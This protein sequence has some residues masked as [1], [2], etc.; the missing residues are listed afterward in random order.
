MV[1]M[2][3]EIM[4]SLGINFFIFTSLFLSDYMIFLFHILGK[5]SMKITKV[6]KI[7]KQLN[8]GLTSL[9]LVLRN[10]PQ[11]RNS[12]TTNRH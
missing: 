1:V 6:L 11:V 8:K 4:F 3:L 12:T 5:G 7:H 2:H 9:F 10:Q